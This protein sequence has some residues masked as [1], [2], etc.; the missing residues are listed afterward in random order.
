MYQLAD[1]TNLTDEEVAKIEKDQ[2]PGAVNDIS[3]S[4]KLYLSAQN[5]KKVTKKQIEPGHPVF[6][7]I[8]DFIANH[9]DLR[10]KIAPE[11]SEAESAILFIIDPNPPIANPM[12]PKFLDK[13]QTSFNTLQ[14]TP[15]NSAYIGLVNELFAAA[16]LP[17]KQQTQIQKPSGKD[18]KKIMYA[19]A[20]VVVIALI[21]R[22]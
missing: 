11:G 5:F 3:E 13:W 15:L 16:M 7:G 6:I 4:I 21:I 9:I 17:Y 20:A 1:G 2:Y 19:I 22:R 8:R 10:K 12:Y 18:S 14:K